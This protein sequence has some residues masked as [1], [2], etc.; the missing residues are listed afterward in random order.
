MNTNYREM[1]LDLI[2][3]LTQALEN[4]CACHALGEKQ[5]FFYNAGKAESLRIILEDH[6]DYDSSSY[7]EHIRNMFDII[8]EEF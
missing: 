2:R 4:A 5:W 8:D 1:K 7:S 3:M 6:F